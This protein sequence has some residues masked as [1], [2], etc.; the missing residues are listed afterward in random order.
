ML[1]CM[2]ADHLTGGDAAAAA[3]WICVSLALLIAMWVATGYD[4]LATFRAA[5]A[6]Q[7]AVVARHAELRPYPRTVPW[8]MADF[9]LGAGYVPMVLTVVAACVG[10]RRDH[11]LLATAALATLVIIAASG[12]MPGETAR[13]WLFD[14]PLAILPAAVCVARATPV[15]RS[16]AFAAVTLVLFAAATSIQFNSID[17]AAIE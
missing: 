5:V 4:T 3:W 11:R 2:A 6:Q 7:N 17:A 12:A 13:V 9:A 8:D 1:F 14:S 10:R 16:L 15:Q